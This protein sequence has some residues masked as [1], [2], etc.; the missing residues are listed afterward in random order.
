[1]TIL[2]AQ[3]ADQ[4]EQLINDGVY[5]EGERLPGV[6]VLSRQFGVS[7][8]TVLQAHQTLESRGYLE[9]RE[10]S[11]YFARLPRKDTPVPTMQKPR[12][13]PAPVTARDMAL[14]LCSVELKQ[15]VAFGPAVPHA[16]FLPLRQIQQATIWAARQGM[17]TLDYAFPGKEVFRRQ[18][19]Q[20]MTSLGVVT[21]PEDIVATNGAQEA[22]ILALRA[23]TQPGDIVAVES[24]SFPGILQALEVVGLRALEIPTHPLEGLSLEGLELALAQWPIK[25]CVVVPNH[26]NPLGVRMPDDKKK[27]LVTLLDDAGVVLIE[28]DIYGDLPHEGE[29]PRPAKSFD[30]SGNVIYCSSFSK[31]ISP[32]LRLGW[33]VP[34][35]YF[36]EVSQQKYFS[37]LATASIPQ[38]AVAHF[39]EQGGYDRYLR[40]ARQRYREATER[41]R[42]AI[43]REFPEGTAVSRPM[44]GFVVWVQLP[45]RVS[46]T[47]VFHRAREVGINVAPGRMFSTTNKY[48]DYVRINCANP[49]SERID[50]AIRQLGIL[51]SEEQEVQGATSDSPNG[52][53]HDMAAAG[54]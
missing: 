27:R 48:E 46:G 28:D 16:D 51:V 25:A 15:M 8:S 49:W 44:G 26:S 31:T 14:D 2:Y 12:V 50:K 45:D 34:G 9:A 42:A 47:R 23:V 13:R 22:I 30:S 18:I 20:R 52:V 36:N 39:L 43:G 19:A 38:L 6:R 40:T 11:G 41:M 17:A 37:N 33:I 10:R 29:R 21:T 1:M 7:I 5:Q 35:K 24:P 53:N 4:I 3:L 32:G 54:S